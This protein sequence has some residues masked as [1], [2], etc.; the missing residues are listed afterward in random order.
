M[1]KKAKDVAVVGE[2]KVQLF[3]TDGGTIFSENDLKRYE[4]PATKQIDLLSFAGMPIIEPPF[5]LAK[6][7]AWMDISVPHCACI[8]TKVQDCVG[9]GWHL[10]QED[11]NSNPVVK[12]E[13]EEFFNNV[14]DDED[15]ISVAKK[16]MVDFEGCGNGYIEVARSADGRVNA[17]YHVPAISVRVH[18]TKK[19]YVQRVGVKTVWFKKYGDDRVI[20]NETGLVAGDKISP[21]KLANEIVHLKQY[22]WRSAHYG[23]PDWLPALASML[24]EMKEKDYNLNFFSS[25]GIPAYA[26]LL[27]NMDMTEE[28][29]ETVKKYFETE[30]KGNPH[31]TMVFSVPS[32][33]EIVFEPLNV[34]QKEASFRVYK[35]DNRDDV[36]TSHRVPPYRAGIVV[37]GQLA[38]SVASETDR[39]YQT[40]IIEPKQRSFEW[41]INTML[42]AK[43]FELKGWLFRFDDIVIDNRVQQAQIDQIYLTTGV[44]NPNEVRVRNGEEPYEG[45]DAYLTGGGS[46]PMEEAGAPAGGASVGDGTTPAILQPLLTGNKLLLGKGRAFKKFVSDKA[47]RRSAKKLAEEVFEDTNK[48][49]RKE[50][51]RQGEET[52]AFLKSENILERIHSDAEN[53]YPELF[54]EK[55]VNGFYEVVVKASKDDFDNIDK[56]LIGWDNKI[57]PEKMDEIL[58]K[59][60]PKAGNA[61]GQLGLEK[62][63]IKLSFNLKN[64]KLIKALKQRG[65]KI[66]GEIANKTLNDLRS[67]LVKEFYGNGASIPKV[68]ERIGKLFEETYAGRAE[69]IARTET[70]IAQETVA[71]ETYVK[72]GVEQKEWQSFIDEKTREGHRDADGQ[73]VAIDAP[74]EVENEEGDMEE[75]DH[76]LD[77][78]ASASNVINCRCNELPIV[79]ELPSVEETWRGD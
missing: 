28:I 7:M 48:A 61:G 33:G 24:G 38:G 37:S 78:T 21:E 18:K 79:D 27:K 39:I 14:N 66:T 6:L 71:H 41:I 12:D 40:S 17:L 56:M 42:I 45:G 44:I 32:G 1:T 46:T 70:G 13:L 34:Q 52:L 51:S 65:T 76:P 36:L 54:A 15:I 62:M 19:L 31:K 20:D 49:L 67:I 53:K 16:V 77:P 63:G 10:E 9:I 73:R 22:T 68:A 60:L 69:T 30:I 26:V 59:Y 35:R 5:D 58:G 55:R 74:F 23:L 3:I 2:K 29:E 64:D 50:F 75:M 4:I 8:Q 57:K 47:R 25:Y 43:G 11:D 72:N